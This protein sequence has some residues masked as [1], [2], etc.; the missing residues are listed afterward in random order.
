MLLGQFKFL[1]EC[2][3]LQHQETGETK[4]L[5]RSELLVLT[6]LIEHQGVTLSKYRL[7][8]GEEEAPVISES[9]VVKAI[10]T[11]RHTLG[12]PAANCIHTVPKEGYQFVA[13]LNDTPLNVPSQSKLSPKVVRT[14]QI[15]SVLAVVL[16]SVPLMLQ[17]FN[18][19]YQAP[20][21]STKVI[22]VRNEFDQQMEVEIV[23][24]A[25]SNVKAMQVYADY[26][27]Q[28]LS[29]CIYSPWKKVK[30]ALS[31]DQQMLNVTLFGDGEHSDI[32]NMKIS[33]F[34]ADPEFINPQWLKQVSIC[35]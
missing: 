19:S 8:C 29:H 35:E 34:R 30:L 9:A 33:D 10:F 25:Q 23:T 7:S 5:T 27:T 26:L 31:H 20:P 32:R 14:M 2:G 13:N 18:H 12:E 24:S 11:L 22:E 21:L 6:Q 4:T 16:V 3:C 1:P 28:H 17:S 15:L